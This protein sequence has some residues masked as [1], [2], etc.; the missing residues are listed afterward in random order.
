MVVSKGVVAVRK[1]DAATGEPML[2]ELAHP[3]SMLEFSAFKAQPYY[4][5]SAEAPAPAEV[6]SVSAGR[7]RE[8]ILAGGAGTLMLVQRLV[9]DLERA[10]EAMLL[11]AT[12]TSQERVQQALVELVE[13]HGVQRPDGAWLIELP[14]RRRELASMVGT[15][16]ETISRILRAIEEAGLAQF[17]GRHVLVPSL[18]ALAKPPSV[19]SSAVANGSRSLA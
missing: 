8:A 15:R 16:P 4:R 5:T 1:A 19:L 11:R 13:K 10:Q 12:T 3:G 9:D 17:V 6:C 14:M 7:V 18:P 2:V